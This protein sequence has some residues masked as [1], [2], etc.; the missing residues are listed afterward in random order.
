MSTRIELRDITL[1]KPNFLRRNIT[2]C[3]ESFS[4]YKEQLLKKLF[5]EKEKIHWNDL[6]RAIKSFGIRPTKSSIYDIFLDPERRALRAAEKEG[7]VSGKESNYFYERDLTNQRVKILFDM[8]ERYKT[9]KRQF[10]SM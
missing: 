5:H 2:H 1:S 6:Y 8:T 3:E 9:L 10:V 7:R 4:D